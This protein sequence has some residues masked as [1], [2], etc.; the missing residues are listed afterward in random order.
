MV[1]KPM[2]LIDSYIR[3]RV[4]LAMLVVISLVLSI[5]VVF[6]LVEELGDSENAYTSAQALL[7]VLK[8]LPS[9]VFQLLPF[10]ALGGS[11]IGL[12]VMASHNELIV[13]QSSGVSTWRLVWAVLKPAFVV[14]IAG[15]VLGEYIAPTLQQSAQSSKAVLRSGVQA[16]DAGQGSWRRIG[17]EFV[18][19]NAIAPGGESLYGVSRYRLTGA[20]LESADSKPKAVIGLA[21]ISFAQSAQYI[22]AVEGG[23]WRLESVSETRFLAD[24]VATAQRESEDWLVDLSPEL[25]AVLL[26]APDRQSISGLYNFA[27]FFESQGLDSDRYM[28]SFWGK[29]LQPL[30]TLALV[31]LAVSFVFGP[32]REAT[33]GFRVFVAIGVGLLF[34]ILQQLLEPASLLLGI[35]PLFAVLLPIVSCAALGIVSMLRVR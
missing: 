11:L 26:V 5:D 24:S 9:R 3:K 6:A 1:S 18:H 19:V 23:Y 15:L 16:I 28:L 17:D 12:G 2:T 30:A 20:E 22:D 33:M 29:L 21:S 4:L 8:T 27:R 35:N 13:I 14:M 32:L 25:L 31:L 10:T 7:Y 34:T